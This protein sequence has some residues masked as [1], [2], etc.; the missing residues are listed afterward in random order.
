VKRSSGMNARASARKSL[1]LCT[2]VRTSAMAAWALLRSPALSALLASRRRAFSLQELTQPKFQ[3][4]IERSLQQ[5]GDACAGR[6]S[7]PH[8]GDYHWPVHGSSSAV[9]SRYAQA[10]TRIG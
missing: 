4:L 5:V 3:R 2:N 7:A 1:M 8:R 6:P 9:T 10:G